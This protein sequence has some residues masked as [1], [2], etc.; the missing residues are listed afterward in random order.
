MMMA[1]AQLWDPLI[2]HALEYAGT[3]KEKKLV[4]IFVFAF[5]QEYLFFQANSLFSLYNFVVLAS[6]PSLSSR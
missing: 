3:E 2:I 6:P 5:G 1:Y 4:R